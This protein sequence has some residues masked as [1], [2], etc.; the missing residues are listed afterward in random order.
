MAITRLKSAK[1]LRRAY[2][3]V[4]IEN[5][6]LLW[7]VDKFLQLMVNKQVPIGVFSWSRNV[8]ESRLVW[9]AD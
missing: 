1:Y 5:I 6:F 7:V 9:A 4:D 3:G 2:V 8:L